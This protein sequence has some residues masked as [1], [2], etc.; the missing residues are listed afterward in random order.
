MV[1][2]FLI[3]ALVGFA[4]GVLSGMLGVGGGAMMVPLFRL[5]MGMSPTM[6]TATSLFTIIPTSISG[7]A[8]HVRGKTCIPKLGVALGIGGAFFSPLGVWL[9]QISPGWLVMTL[10]ALVIGYSA[11]TMLR[12]ALE[13]P[14]IENVSAV[15]SR[16][17]FPDKRNDFR[18]VTADTF[19]IPF[20]KAVAIGAVAGVASGYV[21]LGGGFLMIPLM[22]AWLRLPMRIAS[23]TSLIAMIILVLPA[24]IMQCAIGN[25]D[26]LVGIAIACGSI[27]GALTGARLV[28]R[29][30]E[31]ALRFTFAALLG[32]A[33]IMLVVKELGAM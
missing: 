9:A 1:L 22:V 18:D 10:T 16:T 23:G 14:A 4:I 24:V 17:M 29:V 28:N 20:A 26:Y 21:G 8:G 15:T 30:P 2:S 12:K 32:F 7:V 27:P 11:F 6:S 25:V 5:V 31:R 19:S 3:I 13:A 33:A